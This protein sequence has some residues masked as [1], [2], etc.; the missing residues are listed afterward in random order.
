[1][2]TSTDSCK[3]CILFCLD[4]EANIAVDQIYQETK[5]RHS[6]YIEPVVKDGSLPYHMTMIGGIVIPRALRDKVIRETVGILKPFQ[7]IEYRPKVRDVELLEMNGNFLG[8][9]LK[10]DPKSYV[11]TGDV[12]NNEELVSKLNPS[13]NLDSV[14]HINIC[15]VS[16]GFGEMDIV[17]P[18]FAMLLNEHKPALLQMVFMPQVW[19]K[20]EG[21]WSQYKL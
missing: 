7:S 19:I 18:S 12:A 1:M 3:I 17:K 13:F 15:H 4:Q 21:V 16:G 2:K 8:V 5:L 6:N 14:R 10:L 11:L 20:E 9:R